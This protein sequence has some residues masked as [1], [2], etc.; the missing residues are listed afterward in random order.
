MDIIRSNIGWCV[1]LKSKNHERL[2]G[3]QVYKADIYIYFFFLVH[4]PGN[5]IKAMCYSYFL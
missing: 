4:V 3:L 2:Q 5:L 1:F